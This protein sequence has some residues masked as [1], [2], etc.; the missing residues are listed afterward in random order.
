MNKKNISNIKSEYI[1]F[2]KNNDTT[3]GS[4]LH[5]DTFLNETKS[6]INPSPKSLLLKFI[7]LAM[8][9]GFLSLFICPQFGISPYS[10]EPKFLSHLLHQNLFIC[11]LYCG[12]IY[13]L[14]LSLTIFLIFNIYEKIQFKKSFTYLP[15]LLCGI[16]WT[17][18]MSLSQSHFKESL[19]YNLGWLIA[20]LIGLSLSLFNKSKTVS[21][22]EIN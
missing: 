8:I 21:N 11:G 18:F 4:F 7:P 17:L 1:E 14:F 2:S 3:S 10:L 16:S 6:I 20:V 19:N 22:L 13:Y 15:S 9:S 5:T 12:L